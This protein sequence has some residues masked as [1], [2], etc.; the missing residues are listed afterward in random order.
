MTEAT[1]EE[2]LRTHFLGWQCR[3][4]QQAVRIEEGR[5][6][7]GMQP[8]VILEDKVVANLTVLINKKELTELVTEFCYMYKKNDDPALRRKEILKVLVAGYFQQP[9]DFSDRL[10]ALLSP[11]SS[12]ASRILE[13]R[14]IVLNFNQENQ[15]FNIPC[16]VQELNSEELE[17]QATF[18]HNS[19]FN[20]NLP[21]DI[22]ILA[23][24]PDWS[25][26]KANPLPNEL[27]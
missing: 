2:L 27:I 22:R 11:N 1:A 5:P 12:V 21:P 10:T 6:S 17:Y 8:L 14:R 18:W 3:I 26:V 25:K 24:E 9:E 16:L 13:A 7:H 23:F 20:A 19:I 4:R 15:Q